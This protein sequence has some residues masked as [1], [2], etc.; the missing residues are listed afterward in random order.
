MRSHGHHSPYEAAKTGKT[1]T[2]RTNG[3]KKRSPTRLQ[4]I[5]GITGD[6]IASFNLIFV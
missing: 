4:K 1:K 6:F 2:R 5:N 3:K